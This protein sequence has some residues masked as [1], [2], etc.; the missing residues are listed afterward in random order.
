MAAVRALVAASTVVL[1]G[2]Y[3]GLGDH[4]GD[5]PDGAADSQGPADGGEDGPGAE[6]PSDPEQVAPIGLR[7]L[8][9]FEYDNTL[10]DLLLDETRASNLLLP[11]DLRTPFDN[12]YTLQVPSTALIEAADLLAADAASRLLADAQKRDT[13]V[14][15]TPTGADDASCFASFVSSFGR[16][17]FRRP[18]TAE[19]L[20]GLTALQGEAIEAGDFYL[21]VES[22][23]RTVLQSPSFLYRVELGQ[24]VEG[25]PGLFRLTG[26]E[27]ATRLSYLLWGTLP[28]DALLDAAEAGELDTSEGIGAQL[29]GMLADPRAVD[30]I[31]RFHSL[32]MGY[33]N[34]PHSYDIAQAMQEETRALM[35]RVIFDEQLAWQDLLRMNETYI[36]PLL[37]EHYGLPAPDGDGPAWVPYGDSGRMGLFSQGSFLSLGTANGETSPVQRGLLV[38]TRLFC[39]DIPPPPPDLDVNVDEPP[40]DPATQCKSERY[41]AH[42]V[43]GSSCNGCHA[44]IDPIG[45]GLEAYD[46][47]GRF[48]EHDTDRPEC[49]ISGDGEIAGVGA[50]NG[51]KELAELAIE[52][53]MLNR[54]VATQLYRFAIGRYALDD[55]DENF[56]DAVSESIGEED[57]RFDDLLR[58]FVTSDTFRFRRQ[59]EN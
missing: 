37:A 58:R 19:E 25:E 6:P 57:F 12:D 35:Q 40:G 7:R 48:R 10:R 28:S 44:A 34:L 59:E 21:G 29:S 24:P 31:A 3:D 13:V 45:F 41:A 51:P 9:A 14:G 43:S 5:L 26:Y 39:Q 42:Q 4:D 56:L 2:C 27:V 16:R 8:T 53:G 33:E 30:R 38:Q 20:E 23:I 22:V 49:P 47:A 50:F 52:S 15:C 17:A 55:L 32:W 36:G 18:L 1:G 46:A 11:E 54:C